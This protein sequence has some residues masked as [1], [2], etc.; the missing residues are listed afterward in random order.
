MR[1]PYEPPDLRADLR[2]AP[3]AWQLLPGIAVLPGFVGLFVL[4]GL[5]FTVSVVS[6][7]VLFL[8]GFGLYLS[9]G[10]SDHRRL[11]IHSLVGLSL[12]L[13]VVALHKA[14]VLFS[15]ASFWTSLVGK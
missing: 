2:A 1:N 11:S 7:I 14:F 10:R 12:D 8:V 15:L 9:S 13:I 4:H 3:E 5:L 6:H